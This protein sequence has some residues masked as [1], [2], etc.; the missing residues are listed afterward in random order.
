MDMVTGTGM[1]MGW[2]LKKGNKDFD[3][4]LALI[5]IEMVKLNL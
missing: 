5:K 2:I 1:D 4:L 3:N